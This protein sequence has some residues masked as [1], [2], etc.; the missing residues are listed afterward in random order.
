MKD[1]RPYKKRTDWEQEDI[2]TLPHRI[3]ETEDRRTEMVERKH[4]NPPY[5][6]R[7]AT[8]AAVGW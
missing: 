8:P 4:R 2:I 3:L 6:R 5:Q 1:D 7:L